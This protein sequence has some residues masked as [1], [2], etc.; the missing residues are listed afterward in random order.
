VYGFTAFGLGSQGFGAGSGISLSGT[1]LPG[2]FQLPWFCTE[3]SG[4]AESIHR[5]LTPSQSRIGY[6]ES[7][8]DS[9]KPQGTAE[10]LSRQNC[11]Q[12]LRFRKYS[13]PLC[14]LG[15]GSGCPGVSQSEVDEGS[16]V[17]LCRVLMKNVKT[18]ERSITTEEIKAAISAGYDAIYSSSR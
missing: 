17:A 5:P 7:E 16:F 10:T 11:D 15:P 8:K 12:I 18:V 1:L 6:E 13:N 9:V 2:L 4:S 3:L 14:G